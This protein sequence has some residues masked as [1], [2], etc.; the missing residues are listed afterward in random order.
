MLSCSTKAE[1]TVMNKKTEDDLS[2]V[3]QSV[4]KCPQCLSSARVS[5]ILYGLP[6]MTDEINT[7]IE[8]EQMILVA[9]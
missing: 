9:V 4:P 6:A 5:Y 3:I 1:K 2:H 7:L 8:Q